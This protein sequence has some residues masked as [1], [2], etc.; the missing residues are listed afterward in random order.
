MTCLAEYGLKKG[1]DR[2][3]RDPFQEGFEHPYGREDMAQGN[4]LVVYEP[5]NNGDLLTAPGN[6]DTL[7]ATGGTDFYV[8]PGGETIP[9]AYESWIGENQRDVIVSKFDNQSLRSVVGQL[10]PKDSIVGD[11]SLMDRIRF[12]K[13]TG[14]PI[15]ERGDYLDIQNIDR[16]LRKAIDSGTLSKGEL[17]TASQIIE[18]LSEALEDVR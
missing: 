11:G 17:E 3:I 7:K 13:M 5:K 9:A 4:A 2:I 18:A 15:V 8:A 1:A 16:Y 14:V 12:A 10:Y 6:G